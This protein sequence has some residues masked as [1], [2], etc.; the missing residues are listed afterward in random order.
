MLLRSRKETGKPGGA[1]A[2]ADRGK[3]GPE[4]EAGLDPAGKEFGYVP[5]GQ[6]R[7]FGGHEA[8]VGDVTWDVFR[9]MTPRA[10]Q[11]LDGS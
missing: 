9:R 3:R 5:S 6:E 11:R 4:E 1:G 10:L 8:G 7:H 2:G